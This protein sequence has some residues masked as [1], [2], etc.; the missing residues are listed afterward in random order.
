MSPT[1]LPPALAPGDDEKAVPGIEGQVNGDHVRGGAIFPA[2][3]D[4]ERVAGLA[5]IDAGLGAPDG[6]FGPEL[7]GEFDLGLDGVQF[8][9]GREREANFV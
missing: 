5:Q 3:L 4:Q 9:Q 6:L 2:L 8:A 7:L 1:V